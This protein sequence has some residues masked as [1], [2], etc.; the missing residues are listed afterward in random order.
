MIIVPILLLYKEIILALFQ[1]LILQMSVMKRL[2]L[3]HDI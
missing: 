2:S 1:V 3:L